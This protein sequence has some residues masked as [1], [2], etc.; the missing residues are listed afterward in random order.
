VVVAAVA[1]HQMVLAA[2]EQPVKVMLV[3]AALLME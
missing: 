3:G 2:Q 1:E